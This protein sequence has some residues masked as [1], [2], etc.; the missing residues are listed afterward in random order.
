MFMRCI[1]VIVLTSLCVPAGS[2]PRTHAAPATSVQS[3]T[4][5]GEQSFYAANGFLQRGMYDLAAAE[6][7]AFLAS[8]AD[9]ALTPTA[10]YGLAVALLRLEQYTSAETELATLF[11]DDASPY[12]AEVA[13][14]LGQCRMVTGDLPGCIAALQ[15][16]ADDFPDHGLYDDATGLL[17]DAHYRLQHHPIVIELTDALRERQTDAVNLDRSQLLAAMSEVALGKDNAAQPRLAQLIRAYP[18]S[19]HAVHGMLLLAESLHRV[20]KHEQ[21]LPLFRQVIE[22][23]DA[24]L[25][26]R[27]QLGLA[28][29]QRA[30]RA[31]DDAL[32][33]I[34]ILRESEDL[35]PAMQ[36]DARELLGLVQHDRGEYQDALHALAP[37][38]DATTN[39]RADLAAYWSGRCLI[40]LAR[41][42]DAAELLETAA[43]AYRES[44]L[45]PFISLDYALTL[46]QVDALDASAEVLRDLL[47]RTDDSS[48]TRS[49]LAMLARIES[50]RGLFSEVRTV[51]RRFLDQFTD[52]ADAVSMAFLEADAAFRCEQWDD[53]ASLFTDFLE[54]HPDAEQVNM[55]NLELGLTRV[56]LDQIDEAAVHLRAAAR[57]VEHDPRMA[58]ALFTLGELAF[59]RQE[60][61][62][63]QRWLAAYT[64]RN[65]TT[66]NLDTALLK[67]GL[68]MQRQDLHEE[69]LGAF[70]RL[71]ALDAESDLRTHALFER[72]QCCL[73]LGRDADA[74]AAFTA[75][76]DTDDDP[77]LVHPSLR[78]LGRIATRMNDHATAAAW[79]QQLAI[80]NENQPDAHAQTLLDLGRALQLADD[81]AAAQATFMRLRALEP[82]APIHLEATARLAISEA[83]L[84]EH[85]AA[86]EHIGAS[87]A[88]DAD[89]FA[90]DLRDVLLY[91]RIWS[92]RALDRTDEA[93]AAYQLLLEQHSPG[94]AH[95]RSRLEFA[96]LLATLINHADAEAQLRTLLDELEVEQVDSPALKLD[97]TYRLGLA[98][99]T[100]ENFGDAVDAFSA[101]LAAP[102]NGSYL[103]DARL[104]CGESM[105]R[106]GRFEQAIEQLQAFL[107]AKP[108]RPDDTATALLRIGDAHAALQQWVRSE[109]AFAKHRTQFAD[110]PQWYQA[111]FGLAYA[112]ENQGRFNDAISDY[113][114]I[115]DKHAGPTAARA[116]FQIGEC[117]FALAQPEDAIRELLRVDIL[118]AYPKW[119]AAALY[120]AAR[121]FETME[122][123][124][125]AIAHY[126]RVIDQHE[127]T[128]WAALASRRLKALAPAALPGQTSVSN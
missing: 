23:R 98:C 68:A 58:P 51:S 37:L 104:L 16:V 125:D 88:A 118:Y 77:Q 61:E 34:Q 33:I 69:A 25:T 115:T 101:V 112:R 123:F 89:D 108:D 20:G 86:L 5:A 53:A 109:K 91:E 7:R 36:R 40:R 45:A 96:E 124:D 48:I 38:R 92:L 85:E 120:E 127:Q 14:M 105:F 102:G 65:D 78:H 87:L 121:C 100:Q 66:A 28:R 75:V 39:P 59:D 52:D 27:A 95:R 111:Q 47:A 31:F 42:E 63:A 67:L 49:A 90:P 126:Q 22:Q 71:L 32:G 110:H 50:Q 73:A 114:L 8:H 82:S 97:A 119:S 64:Q 94:D 54:Q 24:S 60:W 55:A 128:D 12:P 19:P 93:I 84:K 35:T 13:F 18:D 117:F 57:A 113:R 83:R 62:S 44:D 21:S 10:R 79:Y 56:R 15:R 46:Q 103:T 9:H 3:P 116:Q 72:G 107:D 81:H 1:V 30:T 11:A 43:T 70:D 4:S 41:W 26:P 99:Y 76:V 2:L 17:I 6:Y 74:T 122:R 29:A 106:T 80:E